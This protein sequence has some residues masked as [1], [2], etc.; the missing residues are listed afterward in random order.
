[1]GET[2]ERVLA[3]PVRGLYESHY[4]KAN[5]PDGRQALWLKYCLLCPS[6][7]RAWPSCGRRGARR[8]PWW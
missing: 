6:R 5:S 2:F 3:Q 7:A 1:M 4:L 8:A